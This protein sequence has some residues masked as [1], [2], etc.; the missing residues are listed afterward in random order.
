MY[1]LLLEVVE[2]PSVGGNETRLIEQLSEE[3]GF[4]LEGALEGEEEPGEEELEVAIGGKAGMGVL[5]R[6]QMEEAGRGRGFDGEVEVEEG[7]GFED[8]DE[9]ELNGEE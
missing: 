9:V 4:N 6:W 5:L 3:F 1:S 8:E 7:R 2:S